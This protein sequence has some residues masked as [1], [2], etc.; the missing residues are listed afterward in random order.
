MYKCPT[1][2]K[3]TREK[4]YTNSIR[5]IREAMDKKTLDAID[6]VFTLL[7]GVEVESFKNVFFNEIKEIQ[8]II[9]RRGV[10]IFKNKRLHESGYG[11]KY[12][13]GIIK[14]EDK[15]YEKRKEFEKKYLDRLPPSRSKPT[16]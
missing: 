9:I 11:I 12:L 15:T 16:S 14:G 5:Q 6:S 10:D 2:G 4:D 8:Q 7:S 1:C 3:K 13:L